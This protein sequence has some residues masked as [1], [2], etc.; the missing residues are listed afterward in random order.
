MRLQIFFWITYLLFQSFIE[1]IWIGK[2]YEHWPSF[3]IFLLALSVEIILLI[4]KLLFNYSV[5]QLT[6]NLEALLNFKLNWIKIILLLLFSIVFYRVLSLFII[7]PY[8]YSEADTNYYNI[9]RILTAMFDILTPVAIYNTIRLF[10]LQIEHLKREKNLI[11]NKLETEL[12]FLKTQTN[13]H[14]L[15]NSLNNIYGLSRKTDAISAN[16]I[17]KLSEIL[18]YILY[19][20]QKK[21]CTLKE[22]LDL[23]QNYI[24]LE[25]LRYKNKLSLSFQTEINSNSAEIVPMLLLPIIENAFKY[26]VSES[27]DLAKVKINLNVNSENYLILNV[28]NTFEVVLNSEYSGIGYKNLNRILELS[29]KEYEFKHFAKDDL[30]YTYLAIN[31]NSYENL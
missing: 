24:Y 11:R 15:F 2:S 4:P 20:S 3:Q 31:L 30:Y 17:L 7:L 19:G 14:F 26:G 6:Q 1:Y 18:R 13:P 12:S 23:I 16:A 10:R 27:L 25:E 28:E 29:Y 21:R 5:I 9:L 22:E 8:L